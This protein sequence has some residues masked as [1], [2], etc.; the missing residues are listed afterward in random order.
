MRLLL[1][2]RHGQ[3]QQF[4]DRWLN[5]EVHTPGR[6]TGSRWTLTPGGLLGAAGIVYVAP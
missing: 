6:G 3:G 2:L 1:R 5:N 4:A